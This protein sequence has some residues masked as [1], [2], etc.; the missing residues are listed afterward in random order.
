MPTQTAAGSPAAIAFGVT[1]RSTRLRHGFGVRQLAR[2]LDLAPGLLSNW[3]SGARVP[4]EAEVARLLGSLRA[5]TFEYSRVIE[6]FNQVRI[7]EYAEPAMPDYPPLMHAYEQISTQIFEWAPIFTP[8][9]FQTE[10]FAREIVN[11]SLSNSRKLDN[12]ATFNQSRKEALIARK[13]LV[14]Y[15]LFLGSRA[16]TPGHVSAHV[17]SEQN[18]HL[19]HL[20]ESGT[21]TLRVMPAAEW[22]L[23]STSPFAQ[24]RLADKRRLTAVAVKSWPTTVYLT[25]NGQ[26][27]DFR[28]MLEVLDE[29]AYGAEMSRNLLLEAI[30]DD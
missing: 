22:G 28:K 26:L 11:P 12:L 7:N 30:A 17:N 16:L 3:E 18:R 15:E 25:T 20:V 10:N 6:A 9:P 19:L 23:E 13:G 8:S 5:P 1:L 27:R 4:H 14:Q 24:Y 21:I 29:F 2:Q